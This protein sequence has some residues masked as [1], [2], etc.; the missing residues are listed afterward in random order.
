MYIYVDSKMGFQIFGAKRP[1]LTDY[2]VR[3]SIRPYVQL[4]H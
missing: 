3:P 4:A 2:S 1:L